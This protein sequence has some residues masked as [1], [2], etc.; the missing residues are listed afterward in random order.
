MKA[1]ATSS[2]SEGRRSGFTLIEVMVALAVVAF[3]FVGLLGLHGRNIQLVDRA[4][5]YSRA[6]LL[7][8][9]LLTDLQ[10]SD[11]ASLN[12]DSGAFEDFTWTRQVDLLENVQ[13]VKRV[14]IQVTWPGG[15]PIE[16]VYFLGQADE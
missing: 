4:V 5:H 16:L 9:K 11:V 13:N 6:T 14:V 2:S 1:T 7:A 10:L 12:S 8:R 3:A 15:S